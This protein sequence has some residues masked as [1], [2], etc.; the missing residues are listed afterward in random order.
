MPSFISNRFKFELASGKI[1][2]AAASQFKAILCYDTFVGTNDQDNVGD[3]TTLGEVSGTGY[4]AGYANG[5]RK[6]ITG[7]LEQDEVNNRAILKIANLTWTSI[8]VGATSCAGV[9]IYMHGI[10]S[11]AG[12]VTSDAN[13]PVVAWLEFS[14]SKRTNGE[15][16]TV[17]FD[18]TNGAI[19]IS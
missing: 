11:T 13:A 14:A 12:A 19:T 3:L 10:T 1:D 7:T 15:N 18:Q 17:E 4:V 16:F 6:F 5:G 2:W 9:L 8:D